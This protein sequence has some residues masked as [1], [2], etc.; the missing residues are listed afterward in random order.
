[1][2]EFDACR[3]GCE[4]PVGLGVVGVTVL[5]PG[6]DFLDESLFVGDA[7][8]EALGRQNAEFRLRQIEP[9]AVLGGVVPFEAFDQPAGFGGREGFIKSKPCGGC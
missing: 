3:G 9:A 7:A 8:V 5:L 6:G 4:V 1:M 2:L